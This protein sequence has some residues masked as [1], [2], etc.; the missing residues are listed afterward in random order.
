[1]SS[2]LILQQSRNDKPLMGLQKY[3]NKIKIKEYTIST[4]STVYQLILWEDCKILIDIKK[5]LTLIRPQVQ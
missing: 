2:I 3:F 4:N 1:M 5:N